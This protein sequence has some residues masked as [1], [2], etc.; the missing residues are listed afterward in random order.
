VMDIHLLPA[1]YVVTND[2][3]GTTGQGAKKNRAQ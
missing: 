3:I 2:A 1:F